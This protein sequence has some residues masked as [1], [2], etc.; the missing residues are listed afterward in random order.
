MQKKLSLILWCL[1]LLWSNVSFAVPMT[2]EE[3]EQDAR[4]YCEDGKPWYADTT[5][6]TQKVIYPKFDVNSINTWMSRER[7]QA[8]NESSTNRNVIIDWLNP[9][10]IW[11]INDTSRILELAQIVY[12]SKMNTV[13]DCAV[14]ESRKNILESLRKTIKWQSEILEKIKIEELK[15]DGQARQC[16]PKDG[17]NNS[18]KSSSDITKERLINTSVLQYCHYRKYLTYLESQL[19]N[20]ISGFNTIDSQIGI[21]WSGKVIIDSDALQRSFLKTQEQIRDEIYTADRAIPR[22]IIAFKEMERTYATHILLV[23]IYDDYVRLRDNLAR[24]MSST[25]QLF[26]KA[27]NAMSP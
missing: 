7:S 1:Y 24:Y 21:W 18:W 14:I 10:R 16:I 12:H 4:A 17:N 11:S 25:S 5:R 3:Y 23:V 27:F 13:F 2:Y 19:E 15:L 8:E 20:N 26:E 22:A 6:N 9:D